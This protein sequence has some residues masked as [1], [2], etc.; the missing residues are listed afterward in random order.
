MIRSS[1]MVA[2]AFAAPLVAQREILPPKTPLQQLALAL[3]K[4]GK[5]GRLLEVTAHPDDEDNA[6]LAYF[7]HGKGHECTLLTLTRGEGGQNE[8]GPELDEDLA[9]L[10]MAEL[11]EAHRYDGADQR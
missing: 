10:R 7:G 2:L 1:L 9:V 4:I 8:I 3:R 11:R 6:L 5:E